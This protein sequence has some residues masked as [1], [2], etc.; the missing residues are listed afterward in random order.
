MAAPTDN[1][2]ET[3]VNLI[4]GITGA[5]IV[6]TFNNMWAVIQVSF[7]NLLILFLIFYGLAIWRGLIK[8]P[9]QDIAWTA[10]K[11]AVIFGLVRTWALFNGIVVQFLTQTPDALAGAAAGF[12]GNAISTV[13]GNVY[14]DAIGAAVTAYESDGWIMPFVLG[15]VI[16]LASTLMLVY[17]LFLIA[18]SKIGLAVLIGLGPLFLILMMF[19]PTQKIF[20]AWLHQV[21][22]YMFIILL[23]VAVLAMASLL[24]QGAVGLIPGIPGDITLGS[25]MPATV[26]FLIIFLF[27][28]QVTSVAGALAAGIALTT[29]HVGATVGYK[30]AQSFAS[31]RAGGWKGIKG[32]ARR[33]WSAIQNRRGR[34]TITPN[35]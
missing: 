25:V 29:Q 4:D 11:F 19:K 24:A 15:T 5:F 7:R 9:I 35:S 21:V 28:T 14:T 20:E 18:L 31:V 2:P 10:L 6:G 3:V 27:L 34:G 16:L 8:T 23:T 33:G 26:V 17:A 32:G 12:S 22:N 13:M 1:I 30:A